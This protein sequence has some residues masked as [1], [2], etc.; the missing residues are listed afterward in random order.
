MDLYFITHRPYYDVIKSVEIAL[1]AGV[2]IIQ[3]REKE[4]NYP[5]L[6]QTAEEIRK[7]TK[8][9]NAIFIINDY[10]YLATK[11][12]ADGIHLGQHDGDL[13]QI[14]K[15]HPELIIG[16][17]THNLQQA[18][19]AEQQGADYIGVGPI[20]ATVTHPNPDP[21]VGIP[22]LKQ[23]RETIKLPIVAIGGITKENMP[24]ILRTET[25]SMAILQ[26]ILTKKDIEQEIKEI[27]KVIK[28]KQLMQRKTRY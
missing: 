15:L 12:N 25:T 6:L 23:I 22:L 1:K 4:K 10:L 8:Q 26:G 11:V 19:E 16:R 27:K 24:E 7:L 21:V 14:R 28:E 2:K 9:H 18:I 20:Y 5:F 17:S 3:Y 13:E